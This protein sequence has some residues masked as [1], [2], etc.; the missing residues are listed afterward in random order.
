[1]AATRG[2]NTRVSSAALS[3]IEASR[4]MRATM[5]SPSA[6]SMVFVEAMS[7]VLRSDELGKLR[8]AGMGK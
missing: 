8:R 7:S 6:M 2:P 5:A 4:W 3:E 1:M